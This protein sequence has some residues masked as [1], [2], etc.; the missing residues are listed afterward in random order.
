VER[1]QRKLMTTIR[2][3]SKYQVTIP[4]EIRGAVGLGVGDVLEVSVDHDRVVLAPRRPAKRSRE[5]RLTSDEKR[6]LT[7]AKRKMKT[8]NE[9]LFGSRGLTPK[10]IATAVKAGLIPKNEAYSWT[11]ECQKDLRA[12]M[13]DYVEGRVSPAFDD[14]SEAIAY[15][16]KEAEK[17]A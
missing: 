13:Q 3:N 12:S 1:E 5:V 7:R 14:P 9:D 16:H 8:I 11:E 4:E 10:E 17:R 15:L 2:L 6:A